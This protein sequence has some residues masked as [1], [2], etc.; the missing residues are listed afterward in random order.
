MGRAE[1]S[2]LGANRHAIFVYPHP[3]VASKSAGRHNAQDFSAPAPRTHR[4]YIY[5]EVLSRFADR[6][7]AAFGF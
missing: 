5:G 7:K 2:S 4:L 1:G 6:D 3:P